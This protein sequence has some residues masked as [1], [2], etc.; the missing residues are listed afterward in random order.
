MIN[1][2]GL[3][4]WIATIEQMMKETAEWNRRRNEEACK[5]NRRFTTADTR[6][7]LKRPYPQFE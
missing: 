4:A 5:I 2:H 1:N 6:I 7:K 3:S